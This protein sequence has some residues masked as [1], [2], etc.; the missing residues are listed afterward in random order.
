MLCWKM[1]Y[2]SQFPFQDYMI[3]GYNCII[4]S[5]KNR[6]SVTSI[7]LYTVNGNF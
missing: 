7:S 4:K 3:Q 1:L 2:N 6:L 5:K